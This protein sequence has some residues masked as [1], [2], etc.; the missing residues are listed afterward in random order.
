MKITKDYKGLERQENG[1]YI[2]IGDL[3]SDENIEIDLDDWLRV[4]GRIESKKTIITKK[5][6]VSG[7]DIKAGC[8]IEAGCGIKAGDGIEAGCDIKAGYGI[9]AGC[10]IKA[11]LSI[12]CKWISSKLRIFAGLCIWRQPTEEE[13]TITCEEVKEGTI[14]FGKLNLIQKK[15]VKEMTV[16]EIEEALGYSVKVVKG[17]DE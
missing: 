16:A 17:S 12:I 2:L 4:T 6:L 15:E 10:G 3:I 11:G 14:A 9:E 13:T 8:G 5:T 7:C 1:D